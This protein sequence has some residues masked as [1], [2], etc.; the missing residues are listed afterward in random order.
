MIIDQRRKIEVRE[1]LSH[2]LGPLPWVLATPEGFPRKTN[3]AN[4]ASHLQ[5]GVQLAEQLPQ[6]S[7]T[8]IDGWNELGTE[9]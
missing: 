2:S 4:F 1:L 9:D 5:K 6:H 3:K 7:A 8:V